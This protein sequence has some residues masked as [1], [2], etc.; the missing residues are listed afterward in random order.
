M[1]KF[2]AQF[3]QLL[4]IL[5]LS[6]VGQ[7]SAHAY[8][9]VSQ[10]SSDLEYVHVLAPHHSGLSYHTTTSHA[11]KPLGEF[12]MAF[13]E[14]REEDETSSHKKHLDGAKKYAILD[15]DQG[16]IY[17]HLLEMGSLT[18]GF[19][20]LSAAVKRHVLYGVYRI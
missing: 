19:S 17:G 11:S 13:L 7:V 2:F 1:K 18:A 6:G 3:F 12:E 20:D 15:V 9:H 10:T 4:C 14:N 8:L 16:A 5:L